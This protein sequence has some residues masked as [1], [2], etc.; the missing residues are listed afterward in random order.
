MI[1]HDLPRQSD[2]SGILGNVVIGIM[3][4]LVVV[5]IIVL[6]RNRES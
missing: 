1:L 2:V 6:L 5:V 4:V 3:I